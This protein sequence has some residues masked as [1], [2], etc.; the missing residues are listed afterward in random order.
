[1]HQLFELFYQCTGISTD[2]RALEKECMFVCLKG[3]RF[4]A[5]EFAEQALQSGA[6]YV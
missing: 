2:T 1:M 4:D 3:D 5:N 6:K